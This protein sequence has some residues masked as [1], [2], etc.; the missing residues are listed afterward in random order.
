MH[1]KVTMTLEHDNQPDE[2]AVISVAV[3]MSGEVM[4]Y[5]A[6]NKRLH[7]QINLWTLQPGDRITVALERTK[8]E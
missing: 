2:S 8:D 3:N 1:K 4:D 7:D 5:K 6:L